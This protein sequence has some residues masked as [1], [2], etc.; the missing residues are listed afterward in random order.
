[1]FGRRVCGTERSQIRSPGRVTRLFSWGCKS[2]S[3]HWV[4]HACGPRANI[5]NPMCRMDARA[6][7][8]YAGPIVGMV[9]K[10]TLW[11]T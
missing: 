10:D 4:S 5:T 6:R 11:S 8:Y 1:M 3:K 7:L 9:R 2:V